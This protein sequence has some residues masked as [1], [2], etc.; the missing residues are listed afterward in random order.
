[1]KLCVIVHNCVTITSLN[2]CQ[3]NF[4]HKHC[5][6]KFILQPEAAEMCKFP[7]GDFILSTL[8]CNKS[9]LWFFCCLP[10]PPTYT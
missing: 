6:Q 3:C 5:R 2:P 10:L 9:A 8:H 1:M 4:A 7:N